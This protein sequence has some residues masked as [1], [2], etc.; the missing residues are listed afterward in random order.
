M[1]LVR[2]LDYNFV[3]QIN[4]EFKMYGNTRIRLRMLT[5]KSVQREVE[6]IPTHVRE[7]LEGNGGS[8]SIIKKI[9]RN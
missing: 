3:I 8:Y 5:I 9:E 4:D 1:K 6:K 7:Y 2:V